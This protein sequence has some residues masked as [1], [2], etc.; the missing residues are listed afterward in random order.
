MNVIQKAIAWVGKSFGLAD[1][2]AWRRFFP[3]ISYSGKAVNAQTAMQLATVWACVRLISETIATLPLLVYT[4]DAQGGRKVARDHWLYRIVHDSPN[5]NMTAVEFWEAVGAQLC[6]WGNSYSLKTVSI[7]QLVSLD[8]LRPDLMTVKTEKDGSILYCYSDPLGYVEYTEEEIFH[9]KG[10]GVDGLIGL[11]PVAYARNSFG[12]AMAADEATGKVF[13]NGLRAAGALTL[14]STLNPEQR[15]QARE[16]LAG[17]VT[18]VA[19]TGRLIVLEGGMEYKPL[20][21]NPEDAQMLETRSFQV[22]EICRWFRVPPYMVGHTEKST[23]WGTGIEQQMIGFLTFALRPYLTR[24]EQSIRKGLLPAADRGKVW[25]E[26]SLEGLL[27]SDSAARAAFYSQMVQNGIYTRDDC[28]ELE[29]LEKRGGN[30]AELTVQSNLLPIDLLGTQPAADTA[31]N[32][33]KS[34]LMDEP[35]ETE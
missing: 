10:F 27:R 1:T 15:K 32:A 35:E 17:Q 8:L 7:G 25:A 30:A 16:S 18:D 5:A 14:P 34:W 33:L 20:S 12:S 22:S 23:S 29:N 4:R 28:R 9:V 21:M 2:A 11:S 13:A 19:N 6:L 3:N 24:I 31:K 26:F